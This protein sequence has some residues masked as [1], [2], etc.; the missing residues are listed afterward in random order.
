MLLVSLGGAL[1]RLHT[2][3]NE[4]LPLLPGSEL[5]GQ[6]P[7]PPIDAGRWGR[8]SSALSALRPRLKDAQPGV[9]AGQAEGVA[10]P[11]DGSHGGGG[12]ASNAAG[13]DAT[14]I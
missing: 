9:G 8:V 7:P 3:L 1:V 13:M 12:S 11:F 6:A 10:A 4:V 2:S 14:D 5:R